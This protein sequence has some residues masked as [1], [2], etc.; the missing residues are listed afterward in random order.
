M[1]NDDNQYEFIFSNDDIANVDITQISSITA[2]TITITNLGQAVINDSSTWNWLNVQQ[3]V[4]FENTMPNPI[5]LNEMCEEYPA[6]EKAYENFK[7][8]YKMVEQ[9]WS[10]KQKDQ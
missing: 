4:M 6:L 10:G 2:S 8:I 5:T 1:N 9:D 3:E 7:T